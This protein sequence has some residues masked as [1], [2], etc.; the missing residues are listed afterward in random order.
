M[1]D[2]SRYRISRAAV[3]LAVA[4]MGTSAYAADVD[5][6]APGYVKAPVATNDILKANN[7]WYLDFAATTFNYKEFDPFGPGILDTE[8]GW[9]PGLQ[10]S[11]S[12]MTDVSVIRNAYFNAAFTWTHGDITHGEANPI[13]NG[14]GTN[15]DVKDYDFRI[16]KGFDIG[17][18]FMLTPYFG[19]GRHEWSRV[20]PVAGGYAEMYHHYYE[21]GGLLV[22]YTPL[23]NWVLSAYGL[24]GKTQGS[25]V[26]VTDTPGGFPIPPQTFVLGNSTIYLAG[27]SIDYAIFKQWHANVGFDYT[28]FKYGISPIGIGGF[29][30]PDSRTS[31]FTVKAGFGY[32]F[33]TR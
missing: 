15:S 22:Q 13:F 8:K 2:I 19:V 17:S 12:V 25:H 16:G 5:V 33:Y 26:D 32:S 6:K 11:L 3:A 10:S 31:N 30:E 29:L 21:G 7:Q 9:S 24:V 20:F 14:I 1:I 23:A 28:N 27:A 18:D 4:G